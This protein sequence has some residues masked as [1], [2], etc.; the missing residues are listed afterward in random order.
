M[1]AA[2]GA[3]WGR[4]RPTPSALASG[5]PDERLDRLRSQP[6]SPRPERATAELRRAFQE[7][8]AA[9]RF[10]T[11][12]SFSGGGSERR[13]TRALRT[14]LAD[15]IEKLGIEVLCDAGCGDGNAVGEVPDLLRLY[16]GCDIVPE[17]ID[18]AR[19]V[20]TGVPNRVFR[21]ADIAGE[22]LP[23]VDAI[24]C[25][26]VLTHLP[27]SEVSQVLHRFRRAAPRFVF[28]GTYP[29]VPSAD[30]NAG[31]WRPV[32]L[33]AKPWSLPPPLYAFSETT[34]SPVK[35]VAVWTGR[36]LQELR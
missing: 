10:G 7:V 24:L 17:V 35:Q 1:S 19:R 31:G 36:Q 18:E 33:Q 29:G 27:T 14:W 34:G 26:D 15:R 16:I 2:R 32:D 20:F 12:E 9:R 13:H 25:R 21:V 23:T 28:L 3:P 8:F 11:A 22:T 4:R 6:I 30:T 5:M